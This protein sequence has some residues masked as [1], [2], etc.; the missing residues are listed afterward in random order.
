MD[1]CK[2]GSSGCG[3]ELTRL[4]EQRWKKLSAVVEVRNVLASKAAKADQPVGATVAPS[5]G[6]E[7]QPQKEF[8]IPDLEFI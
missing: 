1:R 5:L 3:P 7:E 8:V 2:S 4:D 6:G